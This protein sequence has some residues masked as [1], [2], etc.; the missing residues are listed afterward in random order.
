MNKKTRIQY[1]KRQYRKKWKYV[2]AV[3]PSVFLFLVFA[4]YPNLAIFPMSL[5]DWSPIRKNKIF[6]G[7]K[8]FRLMFGVNLEDTLQGAKNMLVYILGLFV[9]QTVLALILSVALQKNTKKNNLLRAYF[10][11]PMVFSTTMISL[12]WTFM[13]DP[14]LGIINNMLGLLGVDGYPGK[15]FFAVSWQAVLLIVCVHI[16]ANIGY[17][18]TILTSGL[19][20]ISADLNEAAVIDGATSW[21][22]FK[23]I[24][25]PLLLPTLFRNSLLTITTGA[26]ATDYIVMM[27]SKSSTMKFDTWAA[28]IYKGTLA[29]RDYGGVCASAVVMFFFLAT[30]SLIQFVAMRKVENKILG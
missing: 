5:Y 24:T 1:M 28:G 14:N 21:Q 12:T 18:I 30:V 17:T 3:T 27:G 8:N 11:L 7:L 25:F 29:S 6:V 23:S 2:L 15:N 16:W 4:I 10:F 26:L 9:I 20:T 13:Y 19:N 22:T